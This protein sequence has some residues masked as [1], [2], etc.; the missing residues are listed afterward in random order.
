MQSYRY[1]KICPRATW[2]L[3]N[4]VGRNHIAHGLLK[5]K[6]PTNGRLSVVHIYFTCRHTVCQGGS[7]PPETTLNIFATEKEV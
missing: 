6:V 2:C 1:H 5:E 3:E 4:I 7:D